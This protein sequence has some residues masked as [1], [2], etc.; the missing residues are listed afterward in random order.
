MVT[1]QQITK[2]IS[3]K[4]DEVFMNNYFNMIENK[5][6]MI[7]NKIALYKQL[8]KS[9]SEIINLKDVSTL[10]QSKRAIGITVV[11]NNTNQLIFNKFMLLFYLDS[12]LI[13]KYGQ[14]LALKRNFTALSIDLEFNGKSASLMQLHFETFNFN[15]IFVID[16]NTQDDFFITNILCNMHI[17]KIMHGSESIDIPYIFTSLFKNDHKMIDDFTRSLYDTRFLC[18]YVKHA[19][20]HYDTKITNKPVSCTIYTALLDFNV[21]DSTQYKSLMSIYNKMG[22]VQDVA[23]SVNNLGKMQLQYAYYDV[24][25]LRQ[26]FK[27]T[28]NTS[29]KIYNG[30]ILISLIFRLVCLEKSNVTNVITLAKHESDVLNNYIIMDLDTIMNHEFT[31]LLPKIILDSKSIFDGLD[32]NTLFMVTYLKKS[33]MTLIKKTVYVCISKKYKIYKDKKT[34]FTDVLSMDD[35]L[36]ELKKFDFD[37]LVTLLNDVAYKTDLLLSSQHKSV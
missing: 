15:W 10:K 6:P 31:T 30:L 11:N 34:L 9:K 21:I 4:P 32:V 37:M 27:N 2:F 3:T 14:L 18:E 23:W 26:L 35:T 25:Y 8:F 12:H 17:I 36:R 20:N 22:P 13:H 28:M 29:T 33:I 19:T 5:H 24:V 1:K 7:D 16:P